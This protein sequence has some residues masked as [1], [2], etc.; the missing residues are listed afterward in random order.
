MKFDK[1]H[2]VVTGGASGLGLAIARRLAE[3]GVRVCIADVDEA[4][5]KEVLPTI[6]SVPHGAPVMVAGDLSVRA[7]AEHLIRTTLAEFGQIDILV[8]CAGGG[9]IRPTLEHTEETLRTT[10]DRNLWTMIYSTLEVLPHMVGQRYGR[11]VS[12]GAESVRNGLWQHAVYN[13]AKGGV[14]AFTTGLA[15]EFAPD[16]ITFNVVAPAMVITPQHAEAK[17]R[18]EPDVARM[19]NEFE[20]RI[21]TTIPLGRG[22]TVDEVAAATAFLAADDASFITGQVLSVNGGSS[23]L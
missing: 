16:T 21:R 3:H 4:R 15:R 22:G 17:R 13:A 6:D 5:L 20:E 10:I 7:G 12:I 1:R 8:N 2:A 18:L 23:M 11:V 9:V 14:H 19:Q